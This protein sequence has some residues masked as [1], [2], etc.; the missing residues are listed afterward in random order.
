MLRENVN[1]FNTKYQETCDEV[2]E[3]KEKVK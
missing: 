2:K 1:Q 3:L